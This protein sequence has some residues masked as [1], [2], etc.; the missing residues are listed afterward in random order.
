MEIAVSEKSRNI[1]Y[2]KLRKKIEVGDEMT[3][4]LNDDVYAR[5]CRI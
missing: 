5:S 3:M 4:M 1:S 2:D